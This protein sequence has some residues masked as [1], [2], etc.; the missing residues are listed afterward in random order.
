MEVE[1]DNT[2]DQT[3]PL[4][5]FHWSGDITKVVIDGQAVVPNLPNHNYADDAENQIQG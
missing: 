4:Y 5:T 1:I 3:D 2:P